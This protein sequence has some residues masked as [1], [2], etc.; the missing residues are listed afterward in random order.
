MH[1]T[2][3]IEHLE[4]DYYDWCCHEYTHAALQV[5]PC[6]LIITNF[7][8]SHQLPDNVSVTS[9]KSCDFLQPHQTRTC[10]LDSESSSLMKP[11]DATNFD[12]I[13]LGGILGNGIY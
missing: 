13:L 12:Y 11:D 8:F 5:A 10:L 9:E 2:F 1:P 6:K 3:V 4:D 7:D